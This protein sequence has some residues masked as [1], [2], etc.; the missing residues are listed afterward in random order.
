MNGIHDL[1]G[2]DGFGAVK[3][4]P[5]DKP[6]FGEAWEGRVLAMTRA[7]GAAGAWNIDVGRYGIERMPPHLYLTA[8]YYQKW[9][10]RNER[11]CLEKGFVTAEELAAGHAS[12]PAKP[13]S[14]KVVASDDI[15]GT[16]VRSNYERVPKA[17]ARFKIG[18]SVRTRNMHPKSHTRL[19]R[20][21]RGRVGNVERIQGC[22]VY[23]DAAVA[24]GR[25]DPKW[26]Y[27]V[28]FDGRELWG[29]DTDPLLEVSIEAFEPY[30][31]AV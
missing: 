24:E 3:P 14:G 7:L 15:A 10:L 5:E 20:F 31:E 19:P 11:L 18:D 25:E 8:S 21:A 16:L 28:R 12:S 17:E 22:H 23:P 13:F 30:L 26:L 1:G 9:L 4:E 6:P 29:A 27:T 2:M